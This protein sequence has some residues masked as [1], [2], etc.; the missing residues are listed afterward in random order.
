MAGPTIFSTILKRGGVCAIYV[1]GDGQWGSQILPKLCFLHPPLTVSVQCPSLLSLTRRDSEQVL[2]IF[3]VLQSA[4]DRHTDLQT[5]RRQGQGVSAIR[6]QQIDV[7]FLN[8]GPPHATFPSLTS[9]ASQPP[10][11]SRPQAPDQDA[12]QTVW[13]SVTPSPADKP[14]ALTL[15][16]R[17][18]IFPLRC[19]V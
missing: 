6:S 15:F 2:P 11:L 8:L 1:V 19:R 18:S 14:P 16:L 17:R 5:D 3:L 13:V 10:L 7:S 12:F 4:G 9:P